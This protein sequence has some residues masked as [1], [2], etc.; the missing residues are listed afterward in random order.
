MILM[1]KDG[2]ARVVRL[3]WSR[4]IAATLARSANDEAL[5]L[6]N[7]DTASTGQRPPGGR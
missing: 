6:D 7:A 2:G 5:T 3:S 1:G 4:W